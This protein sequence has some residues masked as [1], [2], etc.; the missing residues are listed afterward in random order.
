MPAEGIFGQALSTLRPA[1]RAL[2]VGSDNEA[3]LAALAELWFG[4]LGGVRTFLY[5]TGEIGVAGRSS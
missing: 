3:N 1:G 5:L 2:A 4:G